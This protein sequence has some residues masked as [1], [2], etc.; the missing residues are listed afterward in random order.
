LAQLHLFTFLASVAVGTIAGVPLGDR[1]GRKY[2]IWFSILAALPFTLLLPHASLFLE[3]PV[4]RNNRL[5]PANNGAAKDEAPTANVTAQRL[6]SFCKGAH[7]L[8]SIRSHC[9]SCRRA[10]LI[11]AI[12]N[13]R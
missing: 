12:N 3:R 8:I 1:F 10:V 4:D 2:V 5:D 9:S 6:K 7:P 13:G 11:E